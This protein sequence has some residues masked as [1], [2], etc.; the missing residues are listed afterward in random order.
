M[1]ITPYFRLL[2]HAVG[3]KGLLA[4]RVL[5]NALVDHL[6]ALV[7][8]LNALVDHLNALVDHPPIGITFAVAGRRFC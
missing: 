6:N 2:V 1:T 4:L 3:S 7:D 8:H 5:L